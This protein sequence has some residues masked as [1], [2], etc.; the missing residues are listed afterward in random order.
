M[1]YTKG[2]ILMRFEITEGEVI[3][4]LSILEIAK[5]KKELKYIG[6]ICAQG[7]IIQMIED[8]ISDDN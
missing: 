3:L 4:Y 5:L 1:F 8:A 2:I 7:E 6:N